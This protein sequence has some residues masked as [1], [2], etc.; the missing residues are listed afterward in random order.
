MTKRPAHPVDGR[1]DAS[2]SS[3]RWREGLVNALV[4]YI[5]HLLFRFRTR[6]LR[7]RAIRVPCRYIRIRER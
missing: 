1:D 3:P 5:R 4:E 7:R 2:P 6:K